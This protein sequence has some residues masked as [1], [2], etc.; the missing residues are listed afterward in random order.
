[1]VLRVG[2]G[3]RLSRR[4]LSLR[5]L[6]I[7]R[8]QVGFRLR[9]VLP[10]L[11]QVGLR[12]CERPVCRVEIRLVGLDVLPCL[13]QLRSVVPQ[14]GV[15]RAD[16]R[17]VRPDISLRGLKILR[18]GRLSSLIRGDILPCLI[19]LRSVVPQR[20]VGRADG[21]LVRPDIS[22]RGLKILRRGRLSSLI[23]GDILPCLIQL[24][25]IIPQRRPVVGKL[26][27]YPLDLI[28]RHGGRHRDRGDGRPVGLI[29]SMV[30]G[31]QRIRVL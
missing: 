23:R 19:Q 29:A 6:T 3:I 30:H 24:R 18:R 27:L 22:L 15:G 20:G 5:D 21:R 14:R 4:L 17:L 8:G 16:G 25:G 13:I 12:L 28:G 9:D 1:M 7:R 31:P 10:G 2:F 11:R 26:L